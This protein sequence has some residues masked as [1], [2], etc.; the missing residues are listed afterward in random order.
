VL[1]LLADLPRKNC[2]SLVEHAGDHSPDGMQHLLAR[3]VWDADA[4]RDDTRDYLIAH[5]GDAHAVLV[6]DETGDLKKGTATVGVQ[7][8]Y[9]GTA[10]K[11]DNAQVAVY[12]AYASRHG[13]GLID[14]ELYL[15]TGW[16]ADADRR[17][18]AGV[19]EQVGIATKPE[20]GRVM[21]E[22]ALAAGVPASW[23]AADEVYGGN[24]RLRAWLETR[25]LP[26]VLA[27]KRIERLALPQGQPAAPAGAAAG[28]RGRGPGCAHPTGALAG[29][30]RRPWGQGPAVVRLE[31]PFP[32]HGWRA[33]R[34][35][36]L[37]A[38]PPQP[39]HR[40]TGVLPLCRPSRPAAGG[41]W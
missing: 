11:V 22:R 37:A 21:L 9:T 5:L 1:G 36:A 23:V 35:G 17:A 33:G 30:Q 31:P 3:V 12:L 28:R 6:I 38:D 7:R 41:P 14:R 32:H 27:V 4:V 15:P 34:V 26:Y 19:P 2:W 13:H 39:G 40:G 16:A 8:Q 25:A 10:G 24:P 20:L 18:A 29:L